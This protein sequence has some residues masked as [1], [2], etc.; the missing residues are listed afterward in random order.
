MRGPWP[1]RLIAL[2][3]SDRNT[4]SHGRWVVR[5]CW[6]SGIGRPVGAGSMTPAPPRA[7]GRAAQSMATTAA[8]PQVR[9]PT[10]AWK[11]AHDAFVA[12][13]DQ[14]LP[15]GAPPCKVLGPT[16]PAARR[17]GT[18][19]SHGPGEGLG[20]PVRH[21]PGPHRW[22]VRAGRRPHRGLQQYRQARGKDRLRNPEHCEPEMPDAPPAP[23][24]TPG[25]PPEPGSAAN[26][27]EPAYQPR[28]FNP[29]R[30]TPVPTKSF[31]PRRS[32]CSA[33]RC[34]WPARAAAGARCP[35][36]TS[37]RQRPSS[38]GRSESP[39]TPWTAP[40]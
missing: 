9:P 13:A 35:W 10:W 24:I 2:T 27:E 34:T 5:C 29:A 14:M 8:R 3:Q 21:R 33:A 18:R 31:A 40:A 12:Y 36:R 16:R 17:V 32:R 7:V 23:R 28:R 30:A 26:S 39:R 6:G 15:D 1:S 25:R 38:P 37:S 19:S 4:T 11:T 22:A 20:R